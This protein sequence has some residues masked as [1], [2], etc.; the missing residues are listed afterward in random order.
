MTRPKSVVM[1]ENT[2]HNHTP[3]W[4]PVLDT[5]MCV[6]QGKFSFKH[7]AKPMAS[8][9]LIQSRSALS[10]SAKLDILVQEGGRRLR[11]C[12]LSIPWETRIEYINLLMI[13]MVWSGYKEK[14][15]VVVAKRILARY[16]NNLWNYKN[17]DRTLYCSKE[18]RSNQ[19]KPDKNTWFRTQGATATQM[20]PV[21]P[22]GE[23]IVR[24]KRVLT[25]VKSPRDTSVKF[26]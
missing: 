18:E 10:R 25:S 8:L 16:N 15:R 26:S 3:G 14:E 12:D 11:N 13:Q 1:V 22:G 9:E 24:L 19:I 17:L 6:K 20:V 23:L 7:Y 4:L 5:Q 21:R 2:P